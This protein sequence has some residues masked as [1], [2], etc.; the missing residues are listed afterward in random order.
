M[1]N[2]IYSTHVQD[3]GWLNQVSNDA[4]S[5]T[6]GE[7]KR[8]E[9]IKINLTGDIASF[10]DVYYRVHIEAYGWLGWAKNGMKAGSEGLSK[11]L[12]AIEIKLVPKDKGEAVSEKEAYKQPLKT[13]FLDPGHGGTDPGATAGGYQEADLNLAVAKKVQSL[14]LERGY[15]VYMSRSNDTSIS[16]I[17]RPKMANN[18]D[19]DIFISFH[20]NAGGAQG[21]ESYYYRYKE[22]YPSK[23][24]SEMHNDPERVSKSITLT[25]LIQENMV[26]YTGAV[27]RGTDGASF[28]VIRESAMPATLLELGFIDNTSERQKLVTDSYQNKLARAIADGIDEYFNMYY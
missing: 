7:G 20:H 10:Y 9:A 17:D 21:I 13:V 6:T 12:E 5:G 18:L 4:V 14:L 15:V 19:T 23:I 11:R 26:N 28:Q 3:F 1:E 27:N 2:I 25:R 8:L 16:L 22:E 24:N